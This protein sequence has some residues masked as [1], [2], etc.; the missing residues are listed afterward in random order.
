MAATAPELMTSSSV[1]PWRKP[2]SGPK[3]SRKKAYWPPTRGITVESSANTKAPHAASRPPAT[4]AA[5]MRPGEWSSFA[6]R[7]GLMKMP[8]PMMPL[9]TTTEALNRPSRRANGESMVGG[10][11]MNSGRRM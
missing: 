4:Q 5:R 3:A 7:Y 6:T 10:S 9:T 1:Q 8:P 11:D 2:N